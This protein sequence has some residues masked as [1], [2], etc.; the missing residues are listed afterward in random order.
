MN[1]T[2]KLRHRGQWTWCPEWAIVFGLAEGVDDD[3]SDLD[4]CETVSLCMISGFS[5]LL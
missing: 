4:F 1:D 5:R 2:Y 3:V